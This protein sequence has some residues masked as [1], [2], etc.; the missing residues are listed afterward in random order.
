MAED[1]EIL[2]DDSRHV[3]MVAEQLSDC[4]GSRRST[5]M[6]DLALG[7]AQAVCG[8]LDLL[9]VPCGSECGGAFV[10]AGH[11]ARSQQ[12]SH[13]PSWSRGYS[14]PVDHSHSVQ[15]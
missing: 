10:G 5:V 13:M 2:G 3:G 14:T 11:L 8:V 4:Q 7:S 1:V 12:R 9:F 6:V 15:T